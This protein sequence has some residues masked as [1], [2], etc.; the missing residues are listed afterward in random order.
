MRQELRSADITDSSSHGHPLVGCPS[1][2]LS[3]AMLKVL[4]LTAEL[5]YFPGQ[6]GLMN[7]LVRHLASTGE[8]GVVGPKYDHQP[9]AAIAELR[10]QVTASY[11]WPEPANPGELPFAPDLRTR[12]HP[13]LLRLPAKVR[14]SIL[15]RALGLHRHPPESLAWRAVINNLAPQLLEAIRSRRWNAVLLAQSTSAVWE[16]LLPANLARCVYFHDIRSDYLSR[17]GPVAGSRRDCQ[18]RRREEKDLIA[19][20]DSAAFVSTLDQERAQRL[21]RPKCQIGVVPVC[22]DSDY[23]QFAPTRTE[24]GHREVVLFTGHLAHPPNIDAALWLLREIWPLVLAQRP[25]AI[26]RIAGHSPTQQVQEA[27]NGA[28]NSEIAANVSDMREEFRHSRL[29]VVPM[30]FGGGVRQKIL[31]A[32]ACGVPVVTTTMGAEGIESLTTGNSHIA[33]DASSF[34]QAIIRLL[35]NP[36]P[37]GMIES[38]RTIV[39]EEHC[40]AKSGPLLADLIAKSV[41]RRRAAPAKVLF[42]LR[43]ME[44]GKAGGI[45]QM[46]HELVSEIARID[47]TNEYRMLGPRKTCLEWEM[48]RRFNA[49]FEFTDGLTR[50]WASL[51]DQITSDLAH[52]LK[53]PPLNS[54]ALTALKRYQQ[55]DFTVVHSLPSYTHPDLLGFPSVLTVHDLQHLHL[56]EFF[57]PEDI[58]TREHHYRESCAT[59]DRIICVS[60]FTRQDVHRHYGIPLDR[61]VTI[62]NLPSQASSLALSETRCTRLLHQMGIGRPFV[63][64]P[65]H[66]WLH[67]NHQR[68]LTAFDAVRGSLPDGCMLVLTGRPPDASHPAA[69]QLA[70][71]IKQG[72]VCHL[73][74]RTPLEIAALY[75]TAEALVFPSLFEG[76]GMPLVEAMMAGCP[77]AC[78]NNS[79]LPE[80]AGDAALLFDARSEGAISEAITRIT[81]DAALRERLRQAGARQ[82]AGLDRK[83][84]ALRTIEIYRQVHE[85]HFS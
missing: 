80:I 39:T 76:F 10:N 60:E 67:K 55:L 22:V 14:R 79:S 37:S 57:S 1:S 35:E 40:P 5:P 78:A 36:P 74:F 43:W 75:R 64:Y 50:H 18:R 12:A 69:A 11:V 31:E 47:H 73:G 65:A 84:T 53:L 68:L 6:G 71:M 62:W 32:W 2:F 59:A 4:Y 85:S 17:P 8:V 16:R 81:T 52:S 51:R 13:W 41:H 38:A 24:V 77:I 30:R 28:R 63:F 56:P 23:F 29:F 48:P 27:V 7:L 58:A 46:T 72:S 21:L 9:T 42:D 26:C 82:S 25:N 20:V 83:A 3:T 34:A 66:A 70:E 15:D 44:I 19:R 54:P 33:D 61:L 45:E 49:K